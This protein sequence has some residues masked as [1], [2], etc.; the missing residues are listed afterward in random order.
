MNISMTKTMTHMYTS[1]LAYIESLVIL[2][3]RHVAVLHGMLFTCGLS[4]ADKSF[5]YHGNA[6]EHVTWQIAHLKHFLP[7]SVCSWN[8]VGTFSNVHNFKSDIKTL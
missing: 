1:V 7:E 4:L 6:V 5:G 8:V 3:S 2:Y